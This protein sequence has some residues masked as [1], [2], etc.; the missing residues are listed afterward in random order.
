MVK[1]FSIYVYFNQ[2]GQRA[3]EDS[4]KISNAKVNCQV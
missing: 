4:Y 1:Y 2:L 3:S